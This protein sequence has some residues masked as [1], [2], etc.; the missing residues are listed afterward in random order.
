MVLPKSSS[1]SIKSLASFSKDDSG[2]SKGAT[3]MT[4][5]GSCGWGRDSTTEF[6]TRVIG[7]VKVSLPNFMS[8]APDEGGSTISFSKVCPIKMSK[9]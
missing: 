5:L 6:F 7:M 1:S 8:N 9:S 3:D 2:D 4:S